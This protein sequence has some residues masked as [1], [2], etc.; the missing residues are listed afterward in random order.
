ME[1]WFTPMGPYP[2]K[3]KAGMGVS[4]VTLML[5]LRK[6][7]YVGNLKCYSMRKSPTTWANIYGYGVLEMGEMFFKGREKVHGYRVS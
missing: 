3:G 2:L 6:G 4:G 5:S 7:G 1:G